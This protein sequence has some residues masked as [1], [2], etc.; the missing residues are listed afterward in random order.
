MEGNKEAVKVLNNLIEVSED[1]KKGFEEAAND[2]KDSSLKSLFRDCSTQCA[3]AAGDLIKAV[4]ALGGKADDSG[5]ATGAAHRGWV[6]LKSKVENPNVAVLEEVERGQDHAKA[7]Y[8]KA[9]KAQLP[10]TIREMVQRQYEGV[11][12]HHD[13]IRDLRNRYQAAA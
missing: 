12:R 6:K 4:N 1:G 9:L 11:V 5:S 3:A 7:S 8:A 10:Q 2:A 13:Q